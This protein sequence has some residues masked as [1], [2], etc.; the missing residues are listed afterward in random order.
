MWSVLNKIIWRSTLRLVPQISILMWTNIAFFDITYPPSLRVIT[1]WIELLSLYQQSRN[2]DSACT[3]PGRPSRDLPLE[4]PW[5]NGKQGLRQDPAGTDRSSWS[6]LIILFW[7]IY[8][9][10][11]IL[12]FVV[13]MLQCCLCHH[14]VCNFFI[15]GSFH[16]AKRFPYR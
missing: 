7:L 10:F 14:T 5:T 16:Y 12:P 13:N 9:K 1:S 11:N 2:N 4:T 8:P 3:F 15:L 6:G